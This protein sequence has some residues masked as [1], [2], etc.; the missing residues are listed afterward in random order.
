MHRIG[1]TQS[2]APILV[3]WSVPAI[4]LFVLGAGVE[5]ILTA[6]ALVVSYLGMLL[7]HEYGHYFVARRRRCRVFAIGIYP[8]HGYCKYEQPESS[9]DQALIA[10]GGCAAQ[11]V[12]AAPFVIYIK[13]W[14]GSTGVD[15]LDVIVAFFGVLSPMVAAFNLLPIPP[16][17]GRQ[18]W[19]LVPLIW[20]K[21]N[22]QERRPDAS[23]ALEALEEALRR[24][25]EER[26]KRKQ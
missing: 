12:V 18:A 26:R 6:V 5:H 25:T 14:G 22:R 8:L 7:L 23:S 24:A 9:Y 13:A 11:F 16:L 10:W 3:H 15:A 4:S 21:V 19:L 2:G 20:K 17:D 1:R